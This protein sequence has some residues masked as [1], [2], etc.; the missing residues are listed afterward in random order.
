MAK[1]PANW[2]SKDGSSTATQSGNG[3]LL[4]E[5][6]VSL[7]LQ[8]DGA[9]L[10]LVE[11]ILLT[12]KEDSLWHGLA[13]PISAWASRDGS[14]TLTNIGLTSFRVAQ[15]GSDQR[16]QQNSIDFRIV[17]EIVAT[18]KADTKWDSL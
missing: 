12:P 10:I 14:T 1:L 2:S 18:P 5:D 13:K 11:D 7:L 16:L 4:L 17:N 3:D 8:E 6:G 9:S 15:N